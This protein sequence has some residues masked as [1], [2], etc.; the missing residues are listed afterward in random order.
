MVD[1][2]LG[3]R[4][5]VHAVLKLD[6]HQPGQP[7]PDERLA[8]TGPADAAEAVVHIKARAWNRRVADPPGQLALHASRGDSNREAP[9]HVAGDGADRI[10]ALHQLLALAV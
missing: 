8:E 5:G 1:G 4:R 6:H 2:A 3:D 7:E 9:L 10:G